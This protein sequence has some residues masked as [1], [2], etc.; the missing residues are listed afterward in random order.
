MK[1]NVYERAWGYIERGYDFFHVFGAIMFT[2][3]FTLVSGYI[4]KVTGFNESLIELLLK[5]TS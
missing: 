1:D 4:L 2:L 5:N 3:F